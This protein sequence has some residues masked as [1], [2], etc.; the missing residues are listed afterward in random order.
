[1]TRWVVGQLGHRL[2]E[3]PDREVA[4]HAVDQDHVGAF[5][6]LLDVER[7]AVDLQ[8]G[9]GIGAPVRVRSVAVGSDQRLRARKSASSPIDRSRSARV[10]EVGHQLAEGQGP[11]VV[12]LEGLAQDDRVDRG[13]AEVGEE[14]G[15]AV[16]RAGVLAALEVGEDAG[17]VGEDRRVRTASRS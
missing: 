10:A 5:A 3:E 14:P 7:Q 13:Q 1:M 2:A 9:H 15:L 11:A 17:H 6:R 8:L 4:G 12:L 16:D